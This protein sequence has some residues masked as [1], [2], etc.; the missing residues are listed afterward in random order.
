MAGAN[1]ARVDALLARAL[2]PPVRDPFAGLDGPVRQRNWGWS[3]TQW[4]GQTQPQASPF[5]AAPQE[6]LLPV[7]PAMRAARGE[8]P[9][10]TARDE[11]DLIDLERMRAEEEWSPLD[12]EAGWINPPV[13]LARNTWEALRD[14]PSLPNLMT[15]EGPVLREGASQRWR[16]RGE[17]FGRAGPRIGDWI[18]DNILDN[19]TVGDWMSAG[20]RRRAEQQ[21]RERAESIFLEERD[22]LF[23]GAGLGL[24]GLPV[25][26]LI[27]EAEGPGTLRRA[28]AFLSDVWQEPSRAG[29]E[30]RGAYV[31]ADR[32]V[33]FERDRA[34]GYA[35][36]LDAWPELVERGN[37][38]LR[39]R[40][41]RDN[42]DGTVS[43]VRTISI[44]TPRGEVLIPTIADDGRLLSDEE[45]VREFERT[46]RHLGVFASR[47]AAEGYAQRLHQEQESR[48]GAARWEEAARDAAGM[49]ALITGSGALEFV[50]GLGFIDLATAAGRAGARNAL[51]TV[52]AETPELLAAPMRD[53][54]GPMTQSARTARDNVL[55]GGGGGWLVGDAMDGEF[56]DDT[57]APAAAAGAGYVFM[58]DLPELLARQGA[59]RGAAAGAPAERVA[60]DAP[61]SFEGAPIPEGDIIEAVSQPAPRSGTHRVNLPQP[62]VG[63]AE[64]TYNPTREQLAEMVARQGDEPSIRW[65]VNA[66]GDL[67]V[68]DGRAAM[69]SMVA[70]SAEGG[71]FRALGEIEDALEI[72]AVLSTAARTRA[73]QGPSMF[74]PEEFADVAGISPLTAERILT[75]D[76]RL[77]DPLAGLSRME[78]GRVRLGTPEQRRIW[79]SRALVHDTDEAGRHLYA[80]NADNGARMVVTVQ[81]APESPGTAIVSFLDDARP[82]DGLID[83][84]Y[85]MTGGRT[86]SAAL[87]TMERVIAAVQQ[88][89]ASEAPERI[90]IQ[91]ATP[92][93][94]NVYR[95]L[96]GVDPGTGR[97]RIAPIPGYAIRIDNEARQLVLERTGAAPPP[98][99]VRE[100]GDDEMPSALRGMPILSGVDPTGP[101]IRGRRPTNV[102][103]GLSQP[104]DEDVAATSTQWYT[105]NQGSAQTYA[106][107]AEGTVI[108]ANVETP[109]NFLVIDVGGARHDNIPLFAIGDDS[110]RAELEANRVFERSTDTIA[111][112]ARERGYAGVRFRGVRD[113]YRGGGPPADIFAVFPEGGDAVS[114][115]AIS[116]NV[117]DDVID[118]TLRTGAAGGY[119]TGVGVPLTAAAGGAGA[120]YALFGEDAEAGGG[121]FDADGVPL[122]PILGGAGLGAVLLG[123][124]GNRSI[125][126]MGA[127]RPGRVGARAGNVGRPARRA[128]TSLTEVSA[129]GAREVNPARTEE[130]F[131]ASVPTDPERWREIIGAHPWI[132]SPS[133]AQ[134]IIMAMARKPNGAALYSTDDIL[135]VTGL[136]TPESMRVLLS[137]ARRNGIPIPG[138]KGGPGGATSPPGGERTYQ[139]VTIMEQAERNGEYLTARQIAE[140][141]GIR[142]K[143]VDVFL[144][145][146]RGRGR[147]SLPADLLARFDA[148]DAAQARRTSYKRAARRDE[149][150]AAGGLG[151]G[152]LGLG[153]M[154]A[155]AQE[156]DTISVDGL[157]VRPDATPPSMTQAVGAPT[158]SGEFYIQEYA[159]GSRHVFRMNRDGERVDPEYVGE[160]VV[161]R[162]AARDAEYLA[163]VRAERPRITAPA[164]L[165]DPFAGLPPP[166]TPEPEDSPFP[167]EARA[168]GSL[169][170]GLAARRAAPRGPMVR[171]LATAAGAG[172]MNFAMGGSPAEVAAYSA[173]VPLAV[174][175]G[176]NFVLDPA[177]HSLDDL[178]LPM[179]PTFRR[180]R[181]TF[182]ATLSDEA[183]Q[184]RGLAA[185]PDP[186]DHYVYGA[187]DGVGPRGRMDYVPVGEILDQGWVRDLG[188]VELSP[189]GQFLE[190][191]P[192][193]QA[194]WIRRQRALDDR[195]GRSVAAGP[196]R[197]QITFAR[198][199]PERAEAP[200][201]P[202]A[203]A[204]DDD[205]V[206]G[207]PTMRRTFRTPLE[208]TTARAI[209]QRAGSRPA[210]AT[211]DSFAD[212]YGVARGRTTRET[213]ENIR[214]AALRDGRVRAAMR[215][216]GLA[217]LLLGV[218]AA[219]SEINEASAGAR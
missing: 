12:D 169:L 186:L 11:E 204:I 132:N 139:I 44:G 56:G 41:M 138:R 32:R 210:K 16:D 108:S 79:A 113:D 73:E 112:M 13:A 206:A 121:A 192:A 111:T 22:P 130:D 21:R 184:V 199:A 61:F 88:H 85:A 160:L 107:G 146:A 7:S 197:G 110:I 196:D 140:R 207:L 55:V 100:L 60:D 101:S 178:T 153:A 203:A 39:S 95:R 90:V 18:D 157:T 136:T 48:L 177:L 168:V 185:E 52:G 182:A 193:D 67:V 179:S 81:A 219:T 174:T 97:P 27:I 40:P 20:D 46:G 25:G 151:L 142:P 201:L 59:M 30:A 209:Q 122:L 36:E 114:P 78:D 10:P 1:R 194:E 98:A 117:L 124:R 118:P 89:A 183:P 3:P 6:D 163:R 123:A 125:V 135:R 15:G 93:H 217:A 148:V 141:L 65:G 53:L 50:P 195:L 190:M 57:I 154:E 120:G 152:A 87:Q 94:W 5:R 49:D 150:L 35:R 164:D 62:Y 43:T 158:V 74:T 214:Q 145:R 119:W 33:E 51:R 4:A 172:G 171:E 143:G 200:A 37:I 24:D 77:R 133:R 66:D 175:A 156:E 166:I 29:R 72:D 115:G 116:A 82:R 167:G 80:F 19:S 162:D 180:E 91:P 28:G 83:D 38:D 103:R 131:V 149:A 71:A 104:F 23:G 17:Y 155:E 64:V 26:D 92:A 68:W 181:D 159:N 14:L 34:E 202:P 109:P 137:T 144:S 191:G 75:R 9:R 63:A 134:L 106:S 215:D 54:P 213:A 99:R 105:T 211:L 45:A 212:R 187:I 31:E 176:R 84:G 58:R 189:R 2:P 188:A 126:G 69:H 102:H 208:N 147:A 216:W 86:Q 8:I 205:A 218:V 198:G 70:E 96:A 170:A 129:G 76:G 128:E 47:Q 127:G 161:T 42:G 165:S 173:G